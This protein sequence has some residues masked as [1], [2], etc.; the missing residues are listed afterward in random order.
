MLCGSQGVAHL[1][2]NKTYQNGTRHHF[3]RQVIDGCG[4]IP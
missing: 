4:V 2:N 1:T 3:V